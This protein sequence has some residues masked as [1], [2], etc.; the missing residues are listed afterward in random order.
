ME[1]NPSTTYHFQTD[2][3]TKRVNQE[4]K[5]FFDS[6][7]I[8]DKMTRQNG[9]QLQNSYTITEFTLVQDNHLS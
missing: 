9:Y 8:I 7:I 6:T 4:L 3:Q 1:R 5:Q 2:D